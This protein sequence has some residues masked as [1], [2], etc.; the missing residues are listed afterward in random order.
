MIYIFRIQKGHIYFSKSRKPQNNIEVDELNNNNK[1][2]KQETSFFDFKTTKSNNDK[3]Y[4]KAEYFDKR[5]S[6]SRIRV[7]F[8]SVD[9]NKNLIR[10]NDENKYT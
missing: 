7:E 3:K 6:S 10:K 1:N 5:T 8:K 4:L 2:N 9:Q